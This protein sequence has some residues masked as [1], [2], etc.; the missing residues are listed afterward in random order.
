M[1]GGAVGVELHSSTQWPPRYRL[2]EKMS[3]RSL[4]FQLGNER[5]VNQ[6]CGDVWDAA[7]GV[8]F[9]RTLVL[10]W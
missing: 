1:N 3:K 9:P 10:H 5:C 8:V 6:H 4:K 2:E 7:K